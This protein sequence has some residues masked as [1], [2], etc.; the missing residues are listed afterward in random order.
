MNSLSPD[1]SYGQVPLLKSSLSS[2]KMQHL[3]HRGI[4]SIAVI[5]TFTFLSLISVIGYITWVILSKRFHKADL[6]IV[7]A[8]IVGILISGQMTWATVR[9]GTKQHQSDFTPHAL[10]FIAKVRASVQ[11]WLH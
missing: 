9:E 7:V 10:D 2:N 11:S 6:M 8:L 1:P 3:S 4:V 5:W